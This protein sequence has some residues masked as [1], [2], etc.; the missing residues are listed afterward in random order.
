MAKYSILQ[1][2]YKSSEWIDFRHLIIMQRGMRCQHCGNVIT[3]ATE[4][5]LH[6]INELTPGN[7]ND[8]MISLNPDNVL[9]VHLKCHNQIHNRFNIKTHQVYIVYGSPMS[10]KTGYV[11][12]NMQPGDLVV[13][14]DLL[15]QAMSM[16]DLYNKPNCLLGNVKAVHNLIIDN[17]KTRY[18]KWNNAY[19][20]GGYADKY[21]RDKLKEELGAELIL[22][23]TSK[24]EC[25]AR[26]EMDE[27]RRNMKS[28]YINYISNWFDTYRA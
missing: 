7:V 22:I 27:D 4:I 21:K 25:I 12:E 24:E 28:E 15:Y 11:R 9:I 10:G 13:D 20:I 6:H 19:I 8:R 5:T 1:D 18:G 26:L 16:N 17:I 2:F 23:N 3:K 14:M